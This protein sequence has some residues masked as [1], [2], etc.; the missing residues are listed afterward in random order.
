MYQL[1]LPQRW[2]GEEG[3]VV[4]ALEV[5]GAILLVLPML[6]SLII[7]SA[8][9]NSNDL[10]RLHLLCVQSLVRTLL[11]P[12]I[13]QGP[14][15]PYQHQQDAHQVVFVQ[16]VTLSASVLLSPVNR[17]YDSKMKEGGV[18]PTQ[19]LSGLHLPPQ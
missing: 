14:K 4:V 10:H 17:L 13:R 2:E 7:V 8:N 12:T 19:P 9:S 11:L 16:G 3:A 5:P 6:L 18:R 15:P 1:M